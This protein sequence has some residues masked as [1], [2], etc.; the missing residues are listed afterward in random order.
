M[1]PL[2]QE[3]FNKV[4]ALPEAE[5]DEFARFILAELESDARWKA[6]FAASPDVLTMLAEEARAEWDKISRG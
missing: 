6:L 2:L 5:Q 1:T 3:A 4:A